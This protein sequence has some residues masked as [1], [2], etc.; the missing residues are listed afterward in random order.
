LLISGDKGNDTVTLGNGGLTIDGTTIKGGDGVDTV[1][2]GNAGIAANDNIFI[3]GNQGNDTLS[4]SSV[5]VTEITIAG[6]AGNDTIDTVN[7][8]STMIGGLGTDNMTGGA[9]VDMFLYN[10]M[11]QGGASAS[12]TA[13]TVLVD[14]DTINEL[15]TGSEDLITFDASETLVGSSATFGTGTQNGWN[16]NTAGIFALT[17]TTV[18]YVVGTGIAANTLAATIGTV[19]GDAGDTAYF[20]LRDTTTATQSLVVEVTLGTTRAAGA[21]TALNA[22]DTIELL[23]VVNAGAILD[24]ND[25]SFI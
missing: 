14:G 19:V 1:T 11:D 8:T 10:A 25:F 21:G 17:G 23:S 13:T 12:A 2:L 24:I 3:S 6:G 7:G 18:E 20:T 4:G 9:Q 5:A 15:N 22:G 16:M